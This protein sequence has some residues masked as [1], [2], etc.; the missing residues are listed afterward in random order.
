MINESKNLQEMVNSIVKI[1]SLIYSL[2]EEFI[3][4][5][6]LADISICTLFFI[7]ISTILLVK[8][9]NPFSIIKNIILLTFFSFVQIYLL[10]CYKILNEY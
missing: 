1:I 2:I 9:L 10:L 6:I 3:N 8:L 4:L 7:I 5:I